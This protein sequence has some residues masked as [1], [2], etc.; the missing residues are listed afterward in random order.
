MGSGFLIFL[1]IELHG[2]LIQVQCS[3]ENMDYKVIL[4][5][6]RVLRAGLVTVASILI[7]NSYKTS[8]LVSQRT[9][10]LVLYLF[11]DLTKHFCCSFLLL[12]NVLVRVMVADTLHKK[13]NEIGCLS[14]NPEFGFCSNNFLIK[15][16]FFKIYIYIY[17]FKI[18]LI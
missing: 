3:G 2:C 17:N 5:L 16:C 18:I 7:N 11:Q 6:H 1:L 14:H 15:K 12:H 10:F 9:N 8:L 4:F 13:S